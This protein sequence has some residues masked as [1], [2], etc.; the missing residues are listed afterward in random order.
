MLKR[1]L[2]SF[3]SWAWLR[4]PSVQPFT[5]A[6]YSILIGWANGCG[7]IQTCVQIISILEESETYE[8]LVSGRKVKEKSFWLISRGSRRQ[9]LVSPLMT[10]PVSWVLLD[11]QLV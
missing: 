2:N 8:R 5:E 4:D 6:H 1:A 11:S 10:W 9:L 7:S 3:N